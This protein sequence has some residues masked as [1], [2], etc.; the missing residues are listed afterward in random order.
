MGCKGSGLT[1][2]TSGP[3]SSAAA[4]ASQAAVTLVSTFVLPRDPLKIR[5]RKEKRPHS[6]T[7]I[8]RKTAGRDFSSLL[9]ERSRAGAGTGAG[10]AESA[11]SR[12]HLPAVLGRDGWGRQ[13][14]QGRTQWGGM[15]VGGAR[16]VG[17]R[18]GSLMTASRAV[19]VPVLSCSG[20]SL[21]RPGPEA[22]QRGTYLGE[23]QGPCLPRPQ[24][25][26][27]LLL[28]Q[29]HLR[30]GQPCSERLGFKGGAGRR[31]LPIMYPTRRCPTLPISLES[32]SA[33]LW[34]L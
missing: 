15:R 14:M 34:A 29:G 33:G 28:C 7:K 8:R 23:R 18:G 30:G 26:R 3:L 31:G 4:G 19:G 5:Q 1:R 2:R 22:A 16:V 24:A 9:E 25:G 11:L 10:E 20:P 27:Q 6:T 13:A 21:E 17:C 12:R 32:H